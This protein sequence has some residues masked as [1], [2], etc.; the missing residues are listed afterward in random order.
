MSTPTENCTGQ[1][2]QDP[3][4]SKDQYPRLSRSVGFRRLTSDSVACCRL[5]FK[6]FQLVFLQDLTVQ[7]V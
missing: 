1:D 7:A 4:K 3:R 5:V 6:G 2:D